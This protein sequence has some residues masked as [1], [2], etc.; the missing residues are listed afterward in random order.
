MLKQELLQV[1]HNEKPQLVNM[2]R[3]KKKKNLRIYMC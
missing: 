1:S 3:F 2:N